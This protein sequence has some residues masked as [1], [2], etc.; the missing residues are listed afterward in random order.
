[1][2]VYKGLP[3][4]TNKHPL[5]ERDGIPHHV[6]DHVGWDEDYFIHRYS[7]EANAAIEDIHNRGKV[8]IIIGGTHYYLSSLIFNNKTIDEQKKEIVE[9]SLTPD[10]VLILDGPVENI[11]QTLQQ[12]DPVIAE[13]FHPNDKRKLRRAL[14]IY[15]TTGEMPSQMY[16]EQKLEELEESSLRYNTLLFW[17][18]SDQEVLIPRLDK[19]VDKM[20]EGGAV[21]EIKEMYKVYKEDEPDLTRSVWQVIGFKEFLPWLTTGEDKLFSEGV[22]RMKIR[23]RQYAKSQ[24]KWIR[25]LLAIELQKESRFNFKFGGKLYVLDATDLTQWQN[26]VNSTG[27]TIARQF[28]DNGPDNVSAVQ[29]PERLKHIF[30][31]EESLGK[32][33]SNKKLGSEKNWKHFTCDVCKDKSGS[34]LVTVGEDNWKIHEESRKHKKQI[35]Y[36]IKK[37]KV[38]EYIKKNCKGNENGKENGRENGNANANDNDN[39]VRHI[40]E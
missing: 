7:K 35:L 5:E 2:Q 36:G 33:N 18:Y 1:M 3:N 24:V 29:R 9:K 23:T 6:M 22:E 34:P 26:N 37:R 10:Q 28:L 40:I 11:F 31:T 27:L 19:R 17:V 20:M 4:I 16:H 30:P 25:K 32:F 13:K 39:D 15:Y 38:E 8:P 14:E 21:D 12:I